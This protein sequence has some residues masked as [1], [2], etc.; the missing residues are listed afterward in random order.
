MKSLRTKVNHLP[1]LTVAKGGAFQSGLAAARTENGQHPTKHLLH[2]RVVYSL[3]AYRGRKGLGATVRDIS[4]NT[5][6]H[7]RTVRLTLNNLADLVHEH[8]G[9]WYANE[10]PA[11][12]VSGGRKSHGFPL[13]R[14]VCLHLAILAP[15]RSQIQYPPTDSQL[16]PESR[17][18]H[19]LP[20]EPC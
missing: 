10:P 7:H 3:L 8:D 12:L 1:L 16:L 6:L 19:F 17:C 9:K 4:R 15:P 18:D 14:A 5:V 13:V 11:G 20:V 2:E